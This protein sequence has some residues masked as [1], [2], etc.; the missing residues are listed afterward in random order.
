MF[1]ILNCITPELTHHCRHV[2]FLA[3]LIRIQKLGNSVITTEHKR[4][5]LTH[6]FS[7]RLPFGAQHHELLWTP[8]SLPVRHLVKPICFTVHK[9]HTPRRF[10]DSSRYHPWVFHSNTRPWTLTIPAHSQQ[11]YLREQK[12]QSLFLSRSRYLVSYHDHASGDKP[13]IHLCHDCDNS[14][15]HGRYWGISHHRTGT[16]ESS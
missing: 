3:L 16:Q 7:F 4:F 13:E 6:L 10:S 15:P 11:S 9:D 12:Y 2:T 5:L 8:W 1:Q 14:L